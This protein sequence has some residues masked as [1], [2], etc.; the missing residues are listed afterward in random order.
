V[1]WSLKG[2]ELIDTRADL[3]NA[4]RVFDQAALDPYAF[5]RDAYLQRRRSLVYDGNPPPLPQ[6]D[7]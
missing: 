3:L 4:T 5:M 6:P 2:L 7:P 1:R